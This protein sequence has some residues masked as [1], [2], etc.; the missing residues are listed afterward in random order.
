MLANNS[1]DRGYASEDFENLVFR[2][3]EPNAM[4][5]WDSPLFIIVYDD[6]EPPID[7]IWDA[8][9]GGPG[10]KKVV[11]PNAATALVWISYN[12]DR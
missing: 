11:R 10:A 1:N 4:T 9:I 8:I 2:Y 3:E 6:A 7:A 5:R 12:V